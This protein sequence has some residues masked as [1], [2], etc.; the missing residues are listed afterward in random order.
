MDSPND[1]LRVVNIT[2]S[3]SRKIVA[4]ENV[5]FGVPR[6]EVFALL[7]PSGAG[8]TTTINMIR[9]DLAPNN[10]EIFV[11]NIPVTRRRAEAKSH[12]GVCPQFD[13]MDLMTAVGHLRF[14]PQVRGVKDVGQNASQVIRAVSLEA[15]QS[16]MGEKLSGGNKRKLSLGIAF[17][18]NPTV[19][20]LD[21]P[22]SGMDAASK[23][24]M[25]KTLADVQKGRSLVQTTH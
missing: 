12:P 7:G 5:T 9:G 10:G 15:F 3:F 2:K 14:Y 6:G 18:G 17:M 23:R 16:R 11:E 1:G 8:K 21:E 20:L 22:S 25:W 19:L 4:V 24:T 13:A